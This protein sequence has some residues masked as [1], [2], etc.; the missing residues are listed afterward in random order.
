MK[1][2]IYTAFAERDDITFIMEEFTDETGDYLMTKCVGWY[3]GEPNDE[4]TKFYTDCI[5]EN[6]NWR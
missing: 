6:P 1:R 4:R 2:I 3:C 5:I